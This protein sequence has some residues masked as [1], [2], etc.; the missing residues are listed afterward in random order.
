MPRPGA[1]RPDVLTRLNK[2]DRSSLLVSTALASTL[3]VGSLFAP[4]PASAVVACTQPAS[5]AP[6]SFSSNTDAIICVNTEPR[7]NAAGDAIDLSTNGAPHYIDLY[8]NGLLTA[9]QDGIY[10]RTTGANSF[11]TIDNV[12]VKAGTDFHVDIVATGY[13]HLWYGT[14][15]S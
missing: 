15:S 12:G 14:D 1:V 5:P 3:L 8:S 7:T 10:T 11:I 13:R 9:S 4:T 2:T 6:I